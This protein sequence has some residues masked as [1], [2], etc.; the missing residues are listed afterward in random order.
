M[1]II[2]ANKAKVKAIGFIPLAFG[3]GLILNL[4]DL[5]LTHDNNQCWSECYHMP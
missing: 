4:N 1:H 2:D 5:K 3:D